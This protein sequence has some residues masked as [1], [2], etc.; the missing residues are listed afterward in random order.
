MVT[1]GSLKTLVFFYLTARHLNVEEILIF[2]AVRTSDLT[3]PFTYSFIV[4][5]DTGYGRLTA[6]VDKNVFT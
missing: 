1:T 6:D 2:T 3:Y 4:Q 5:K